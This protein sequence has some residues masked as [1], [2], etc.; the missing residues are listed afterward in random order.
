MFSQTDKNFHWIFPGI[1]LWIF[2]VCKC[3][4][5][6]S[7]SVDSP[8]EIFCSKISPEDKCLTIRCQVCIAC[9]LRQ[10]QESLYNSRP[11]GS[12]QNLFFKLRGSIFYR[13]TERSFNCAEKRR[14]EVNGEFPSEH[15]D[16]PLAP[17]SGFWMKVAPLPRDQKSRLDN[18]SFLLLHIRYF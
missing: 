16:F 5:N 14:D 15:T 2:P 10:R 9:I 17:K 4:C 7:S 8:T 12:S 13:S 11:K 18:V 3:I 1:L 6:L